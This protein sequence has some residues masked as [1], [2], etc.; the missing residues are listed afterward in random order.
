MLQAGESEGLKAGVHATVCGM[1][2]VCAGYNG[3]AWLARPQGPRR[4]L[5]VNFVVYSLLA[6]WELFRVRDHLRP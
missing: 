1:A 5:A 4:H 3:L 2:L 6:G